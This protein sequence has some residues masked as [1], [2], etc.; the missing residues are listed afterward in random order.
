MKTFALIINLLMVLLCI[1]CGSNQ[2]HY[3]PVKTTVSD[4]SVVTS[5]GSSSGGGGFVTLNS[6]KLLDMSSKELADMLRSASPEIFQGLPSGWSPERLAKIIE[7]VRYKP[8]SSNKR[9]LTDAET[10]KVEETDLV[11]DYGKDEKGEYIAALKP[12]F[13]IYASKEVN[14]LEKDD[15]KIV[16]KDVQRQLLHE[17]VHFLGYGTDPNGK[18]DIEADQLAINILEALDNDIITCS[19]KK[20][21]K[22][23]N[24]IFVTPEDLHKLFTPNEKRYFMWT[25]HRTKGYTVFQTSQS[26]QI[27]VLAEV[28]K[29]TLSGP[30]AK[31]TIAVIDNY[32]GGYYYDAQYPLNMAKY[33]TE[34]DSN[35]IIL[36]N[37]FNKRTA[38]TKSIKFSESGST[39]NSTM[40]NLDIEE[41]IKIKS[42]NDGSYK[43]TF[44]YSGEYLVIDRDVLKE[45]TQ[46][47]DPEAIIDQETGFADAL[48]YKPNLLTIDKEYHLTKIINTSGS[49]EVVCE[50]D[51]SNVI[52]F[53]KN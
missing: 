30:I 7:N 24:G 2:D 53:F 17:V 29:S 22:R 35:T 34:Q 48:S 26:S 42:I 50:R 20:P 47:T 10:G 4:T 27:G 49:Y 23:V 15:L 38:S 43:G 13:H 5:N 3:Y 39:N 9:K 28:A 45:V 46:S 36:E 6:K 40:A 14:F 21:F 18:D 8:N 33:K 41:R 12:Y 44:N 37:T 11:F 16:I 32:T 51:L 19:T 25:V 52:D 1:A 31:M